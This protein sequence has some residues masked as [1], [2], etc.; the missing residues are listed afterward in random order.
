MDHYVSL[1]GLANL[2]VYSF[3]P[4]SDALTVLKKHKRYQP[5]RY[6]YHCTFWQIVRVL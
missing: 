1:R 2:D 6:V 3:G 4:K 5:L